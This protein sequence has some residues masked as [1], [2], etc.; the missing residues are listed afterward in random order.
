MEL[1]LEEA[2]GSRGSATIVVTNTGEQPLAL[3][4]YLGDN[5]MLPSG[6][7]VELPAGQHPRSC[8][9]WT[10]L[11]TQF[12]ELAPGA[13]QRMGVE[14]AVPGDAVGSYWTKIYIEETSQPE[15]AVRQI[16]GR[17]YSVFM[18]QRL[19]IRLCE[20][21]AGT[22]TLAARVANVTIPA[23]K[24][25][26][27]GVQVTVEN[28]GTRIARCSGRVELRDNGG[29]VLETLPLGS[30]GEFWVYPGSNRELSVEAT[31]PLPAGVFTALAIV[32]FGAEYLV[33]GDAVF[34]VAENA[35][36]G[37]P[38]AAEERQ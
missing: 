31:A 6:Q 30:R 37:A 8:A 2:P 34:R 1:H 10:T 38:P 29:G 23:V 36:A 24:A 11:P 15:P 12:L 28:S 3:K 14:V 5:Q 13:S 32:D 7:E 20:D 4:I 18:K 27:P 25:G 35:G 16:N 21:A 19:A 9:A 26:I 22:G 33:A 17:S